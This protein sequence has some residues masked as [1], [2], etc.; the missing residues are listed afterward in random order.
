MTRAVFRFRNYT[1]SSDET[2]APTYEATC[3]AGEDTD[4]GSVSGEHLDPTPVEKWIAEH[5]RDTTRTRHRRTFSDYTDVQ[6]DQW[7]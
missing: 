6:P 4:C 7:L 3:V 1:M 5:T 2:A